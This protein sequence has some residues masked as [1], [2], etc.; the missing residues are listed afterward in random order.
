MGTCFYEKST[1]YCGH[2]GR[3]SRAT[4]IGKRSAAG[5]WCWDCGVSLC[6]AGSSNVHFSASAWHES[7][8][9]CG[10]KKE[11]EPLSESTAGRELGFNNHKP[12]RKKGVASCCS[13]AWGIEPDSLRN[14]PDIVDEYGREFTLE[15]FRDI[16]TECPI[17]STDLIGQEFF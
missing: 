6:K 5:W 13:F 9:K 4:L 2:C 11:D 3:G 1:D 10:K 15:Q 8:P 14:Y 17:Q 12:G 16:L 7:C